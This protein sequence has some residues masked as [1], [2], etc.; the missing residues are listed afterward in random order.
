MDAQNMATTWARLAG[1]AVVELIEIPADGPPIE[2]RFH[3]D[4]VAAMQPVPADSLVAIGWQWDE[5]GFSPPPPPPP[6]PMPAI[7]ARQLRL[8]L[9][10]QGRTLSQVDGAIE[11]LPA[12]TRDAARI[13]WQF[14][15][16]YDRAHPLIAGLGAA[17][18]FS[19]AEID[20]GFHTA[21]TL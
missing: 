19:A 2:E 21:A 13:E 10:G 15:H 1:G 17:L 12:E 3:P 9:I 4:L 5:A 6:P 7:T 16:T 20:A 8:W 18:G 11:Q 14:A